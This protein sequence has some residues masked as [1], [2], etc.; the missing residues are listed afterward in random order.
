MA[1]PGQH[2]DL[3]SESVEDHPGHLRT[4]LENHLL[5]SY[6]S[7]RELRVLRLIDRSKATLPY[8]VEQSITPLQQRGLG[9]GWTPTVSAELA[10]RDREISRTAAAGVLT[11]LALSTLFS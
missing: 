8:L 10:S 6:G 1:Q 5:N 4:G 9:D 11:S 2:A 7:I 3:A